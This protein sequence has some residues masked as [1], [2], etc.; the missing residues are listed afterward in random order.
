MGPCRERAAGWALVG[1]FQW[2]R[3]ALA[4]EQPGQAGREASGWPGVPSRVVSFLTGNLRV[5]R[6]VLSAIPSTGMIGML[7]AVWSFLCHGHPSSPLTERNGLYAHISGQRLACEQNCRDA[8]THLRA[9]LANPWP[10]LHPGR[11][12]RGSYPGLGGR[13]EPSPVPPPGTPTS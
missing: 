2:A 4:R 11:C 1:P 8:V 13:W 5:P 3:V 12:G 10:G 9:G 7:V 6:R